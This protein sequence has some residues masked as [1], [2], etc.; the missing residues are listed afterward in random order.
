MK[1]HKVSIENTHFSKSIQIFANII[2]GNEM[3]IQHECVYIKSMEKSTWGLI[4][5]D[6]FSFV[7]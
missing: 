3:I 1:L 2:K 6:Q 5:F 7:T 4:Y